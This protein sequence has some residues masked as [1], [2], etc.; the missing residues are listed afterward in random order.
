MT[1]DNTVKGIFFKSAE[2]KERFLSTMLQRGKVDGGKFDAEYG[3]AFYILTADLWTWENVQDYITRRGIDFEAM[4]KEV[5]FS[6]GYS[7]LPKLASNLFNGNEPIQAVDIPN[8]LD[9]SNFRI[10]MSAFLL[11][12]YSLREDDFK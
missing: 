3:A 2:H 11:R 12:R 8:R 5:D 10:A 9:E 7:I 6:G 4:L 1:N